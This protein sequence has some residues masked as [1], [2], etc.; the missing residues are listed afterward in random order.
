MVST[1]KMSCERLAGVHDKRRSKK[2]DI[3]SGGSD[4][5][6]NEPED[7]ISARRIFESRYVLG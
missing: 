3:L 1:R 7:E 5:E 4:A 6:Q 2:Q